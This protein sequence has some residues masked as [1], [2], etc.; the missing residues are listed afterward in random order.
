MRPAM[1]GRAAEGAAAASTARASLGLGPPVPPL[2]RGGGGGAGGEAAAAVAASIK[3]PSC[4]LPAQPGDVGGRTAEPETVKTAEE[5]AVAG[6]HRLCRAP[7]VAEGEVPPADQDKV[8]CHTVRKSSSDSSE[9]SSSVSSHVP[10]I[11]Q[12][13]KETPESPASAYLLLER[14]PPVKNPHPWPLEDVDP[15]SSTQ[16][17]M[18]GQNSSTGSGCTL[19]RVEDASSPL[20]TPADPL[21]VLQLSGQGP[22]SNCA[23]GLARTTSDVL[24]PVPFILPRSPTEQEAEGKQESTPLET[25]STFQGSV[26]VSQ[27]AFVLP[28]QPEFSHDT[29]LP[30]P[31]L[32]EGCKMAAEKEGSSEGSEIP[33][34]ATSASFAEVPL[35]GPPEDDCVLA[36]S[37]SQGSQVT[38]A[39]EEKTID[40]SASCA[41]EEKLCLPDGCS[42]QEAD[43]ET[44]V[45]EPCSGLGPQG[46]VPSKASLLLEGE[47]VPETPCEKPE[48]VTLLDEG[49]SLRLTISQAVE[50]AECSAV[51]EAF[52]PND[53]HITDPHVTGEPALVVSGK[54]E[55]G[56]LDNPNKAVLEVQSMG[57]RINPGMMLKQSD[58]EPQLQRR[59]GSFPGE[60]LHAHVP[61][62]VGS[63]PEHLAVGAEGRDSVSGAGSAGAAAMEEN[64][65]GS[66]MVTCEEEGGLSLRRN[67]ATPVME[68]SDEPLPFSLEKPE[69]RERT[70]GLAT[71]SNP[72]SQK[73]PSVFARVCGPE[74]KAPGPGQLS[75]LFRGDLFNFPSSQ[76][77]D[78]PSRTWKDQQKCVSLGC[79]QVSSSELIAKEQAVGCAKVGEAMEVDVASLQQGENRRAPK[80]GHVGT[81]EEKTVPESGSSNGKSTQVPGEH[82]E[83]P[84]GPVS[85]ATQTASAAQV[86]VGTSMACP[87]LQQRST[88]VQTERDFMWRPGSPPEASPSQ[89]EEEFELPHPPAGRVL[90]RHVRTIREVRTLITRVIT[91]VYY[92]DG[93]EVERQVV[94]EREEPHVDCYECEVDVSPSRTGAFSLTS[95]DLGDLSSFSS[96]ASGPQHTSSGGSSALS[97]T[98]SRANS[99]GPRRGSQ[100]LALLTARKLSPKKGIGFCPAHRDQGKAAAGDEAEDPGPSNQQGRGAPLTPRGRGRR[101]RPTSRSTGAR[102]FKEADLSAGACLDG[103]PSL[104]PH[105]EGLERAEPPRCR[106][107]SPEIPLQE[108]PSASDDPRLPSPGS[109]VVGLRVV[110]KWSSNGYFYSGTITQ[111][112]GGAKYRLLFDDGY[113]CDVL[114]RDVL[115]CDPLPLET[116][117]TALSEDEYFSAGVVKGHRKEAGEL[118]YC[119]EK[120]GQQKWYRR[121]AV[122]LSLEQGNRLREQF[123]LGPF[124]PA[125]PLTRAADIS[126]DNLVEGKRKR[127]SV[128]PPSPSSGSTTPIRKSPEPLSSKRKL[129]AVSEEE[130]SPAK[131]GRRLA[132]SKAGAANAREMASPSGSGKYSGDHLALDHRWGPLPQNKTLFLGYAFL[133]SMANTTEELSSYQKTAVSSEEEEEFVERVPYNKSYAE[134]QLQAGGGF[135]LDDFNESQCSAAYECLLIADRHCRTRKYFLCLARG[136][137]CV[138]H[139]WVHD[140][141]LANQTQ[142]YKNYLLPAGYS[143]EEERLLEWHPR[144]N[145]FQ[146]LRVLL[147]SDESQNFLELW[148]EIL[149]MGGAASVKQQESSTWKNDVSLGVFDVVVTDAS[150]PAAMVPCAKA[151]QLPVVTQEWVIQSLIVGERAGFKYPKYQHDYVPC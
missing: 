103:Q 47:A 6:R 101:G 97:A 44:S 80:K 1:R 98:R 23:S 112:V 142:N 150:C 144:K 120:D 37:A 18:F 28:S 79:R 137:P 16:E 91:D 88:S 139:M 29:F 110:A 64:P 30:T 134:L 20:S 39:K 13:H 27:D 5:P 92:R 42:E 140:S 125:T 138:S 34:A 126:L 41:L 66:P 15:V 56:P 19:S 94:E 78:E 33:E 77:E 122:I 4:P 124:Q 149:M 87:P 106:S 117:V 9:G 71:A 69:A 65:Q 38:T 131:R 111:D 123:G 114:A 61:P 147:V 119:I 54:L 35:P 52:S 46:S 146:R 60:I 14:T 22:L 148:S 32:E 99:A 108:Q 51:R 128:A 129:A 95:G 89:K 24:Q 104:D 127:R 113:E 102:D 93:T 83:D 53:P 55:Q 105:L 145:P 58:S 107:G 136:I 132:L 31:S 75:S 45:G 68:E 62:V 10:G 25:A 81:P 121:T 21:H 130:Q 133:L 73:T 8:G 11:M 57:R 109:C 40:V 67:L 116:E 96:K 74:E 82:L 115:L 76:E 118:F 43:E 50:Q 49:L 2:R 17:D 141:C 90:Q 100:D 72:S 12:L 59:A 135:I 86:E 26:P 7:M 3:G 143:L 84:A 85:A 63:D 36:L 48:E 151:L 70:N